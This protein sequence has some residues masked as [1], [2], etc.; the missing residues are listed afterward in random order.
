MRYTIPLLVCFGGAYGASK[1]GKIGSSHIPDDCA[2]FCGSF[3]KCGDPKPTC[4]RDGNC[5]NLYTDSAKKL[6]YGLGTIPKS[7]KRVSCRQAYSHFQGYQHWEP[8]SGYAKGFNNL[9]VSCFA[10]AMMQVLLHANP[11]REFFW[12]MREWVEQVKLDDELIRQITEEQLDKSTVA[13]LWHWS[14]LNDFFQIYDYMFRPTPVVFSDGTTKYRIMT[15]DSFLRRTWGIYHDVQEDASEAMT[16]FLEFFQDGPSFGDLDGLSP[17]ILF[18][19]AEINRIPFN[20]DEFGID[21]FVGLKTSYSLQCSGD[22]HAP[23]R[24]KHE[25]QRVYTD[26]QFPKEVV[27]YYRRQLEGIRIAGS[28]NEG[29]RPLAL[30]ELFLAASKPQTEFLDCETCPRLPGGE[31]SRTAHQKIPFLSEPSPPALILALKRFATHSVRLSVP[32]AGRTHNM[33]I[34]KI[35]NEVYIPLNFELLCM[36]GSQARGRYRL[37]GVVFHAGSTANSGHYISAFLD[38]DSDMWIYAN[39]ARVSR[40]ASYAD[41]QVA[42]NEN[43]FYGSVDPYILVYEKISPGKAVAGDCT[44]ED[45]GGSAPVDPSLGAARAPAGGGAPGPRSSVDGAPS[46]VPAAA[47]PSSSSG[48]GLPLGG[49]GKPS[50]EAPAACWVRPIGHIESAPDFQFV[51]YL[52]FNSQALRTWIQA[53]VTSSPAGCFTRLFEDIYTQL[54]DSE[55]CNSPVDVS[56]V[57]GSLARRTPEFYEGMEPKITAKIDKSISMSWGII[58]IL[59]I[60]DQ[61]RDDVGRQLPSYTKLQA[62]LVVKTLEGV[63]V[64]PRDCM[65]PLIIVIDPTKPEFASYELRGVLFRHSEH[66]FSAAFKKEA[67]WFYATRAGIEAVDKWDEFFEGKKEEIQF[68]VME[69]VG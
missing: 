28:G 40:H 64:D 8:F 63:I 11:T 32:I 60:M 69:F 26:I 47:A 52:V 13:T 18:T 43:R 44:D 36:P 35:T 19:L 39:D 48:L 55:N 57:L 14:F 12:R 42:V 3:V 67:R 58:D 23:L 9:G 24:V 7:A 30:W 6:H 4:Q 20:F 38:P 22:C 2:L 62:D 51:A 56:R 10:N 68:M 59:L 29:T 65:R 17:S 41:I 25:I 34:A 31:I 21:K 37:V 46:H 16:K 33:K 1:S 61:V 50:V 49:S 45:R 15:P 5:S 53:R 66:G 54:D 27:D